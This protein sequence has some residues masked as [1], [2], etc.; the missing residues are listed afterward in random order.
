M[1]CPDGYD[2]LPKRFKLYI[3]QLEDRVTSL[4]RSQPSATPS[5]VHVIDYLSQTKTYLPD[6]TRLV[7]TV[8]NDEFEVLHSED[9]DG[10][11]I[12]SSRHGLA[13]LPG[14]SNVVYI[15]VRER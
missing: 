2:A 5:R 14:V 3:R 6:A 10:I 4:E 13:V 12:R 11:E 15:V 9:H 7:F 8:K 1:D